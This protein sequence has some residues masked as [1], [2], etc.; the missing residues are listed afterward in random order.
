MSARG[1]ALAG[2][3]AVVSLAA[4]AFGWSSHPGLA[5][6]PVALDGASLFVT[7]GCATCHTGPDSRA[8]MGEFP[9]LSDARAWAADRRPGLGAEEY[10]AESIREPWAF[11]S[12]EFV[13]NGPTI[14]MP[15][16]G[17]AQAEID[18]LVTYLLTDAG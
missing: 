7:K 11:I 15:A 14:G 1:A 4:A 12:P 10:L 8:M 6:Q 9:D 3:A 16:L 18:A 17:V 5:D 13:P 2:A